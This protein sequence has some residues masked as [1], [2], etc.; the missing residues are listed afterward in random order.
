MELGLKQ[1]LK[2][3]PCVGTFLKLPRPEIVDILALA[4]FDFVICDMEHAQ[5]TESEAREVIRA[6]VAAGIPVVVRLP[7]PVQGVVNRLLEA[8]ASG[9][10]MPRLRKAQETDAL[11][12]MMHF[13]P[14]GTRSVGNANLS[15]KYGSVNITDYLEKENARVLTIGQFETREIDSPIEPMFEGLDIAFIGP[16]DLAVD[17]G[18]PGKFSD[19][20]VQSR[21][22]EIEKAAAKAGT[23]MG[24]FAANLDDTQYYLERGYRY[25]AVSG[26]VSLISNG[27]KSLIKEFRENFEVLSANK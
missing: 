26:D 6:G 1:K 3:G 25:L 12:S 5:I 23:F 15:A 10:Q 7:E 11:H 18:V 13:P 24:A 22:A 8:G 2:L 27:A 19:P 4:G 14:L 16:T 21:V 20:G 17:F 9:I